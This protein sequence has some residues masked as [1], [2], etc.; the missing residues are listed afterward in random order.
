MYSFGFFNSNTSIITF[1]AYTT[2]LNPETFLFVE[3]VR[4]VIVPPSNSGKAHLPNFDK[5][6]YYEVMDHLNLEP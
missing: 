1:V 3:E 6:G 5:M 4:Y 2:G